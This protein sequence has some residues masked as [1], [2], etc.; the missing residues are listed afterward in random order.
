MTAK[1]STKTEKNFRAGGGEFSGWPEYIPLFE[2][3]EDK[4]MKCLQNQSIL[5]LS[6][7][8]IYM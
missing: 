6:V 8:N 4:V 1:E 2:H 5:S 3:I 7:S